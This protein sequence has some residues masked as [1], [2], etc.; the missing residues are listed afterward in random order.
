M[1]PTSARDGSGGRGHGDRHSRRHPRP[2]CRARSS[3]GL[4][5]GHAVCPSYET[6]SSAELCSRNRPPGAEEVSVDS[7]AVGERRLLGRVRGEKCLHAHPLDRARRRGRYANPEDRP[8]SSAEDTLERDVSRLDQVATSLPSWRAEAATSEHDQ[9]RRRPRPIRCARSSADRKRVAALDT[10]QVMDVR[11]RPTRE[12]TTT[13][14]RHR[15][16]NRIWS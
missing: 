10:P 16:T 7:G 11:P 6:G 8:S 14:A 4:V 9:T 3:P 2:L 12:S 5:H 1:Q 13:G 15:S